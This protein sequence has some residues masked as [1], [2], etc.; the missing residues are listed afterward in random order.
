[1][2]LG[3][4]HSIGVGFR[5]GVEGCWGRQGACREQ[6]WRVIWASRRT[7]EFPRSAPKYLRSGEFA[8]EWTGWRPQGCPE[9]QNEEGQGGAEQGGA[10][11]SSVK[12]GARSAL[13]LQMSSSMSLGMCLRIGVQGVGIWGPPRGGQGPGRRIVKSQEEHLKAPAKEISLDPLSKRPMCLGLGSSH[14]MSLHALPPGPLPPP[15]ML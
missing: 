13:T 1:M 7:P 6:E 14:S 5:P 4:Q 2:G 11:G 12:M 9:A 3:P 10:G 8:K 15:C